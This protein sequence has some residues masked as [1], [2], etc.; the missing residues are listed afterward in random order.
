MESIP[1]T[2][3]ALLVSVTFGGEP[4]RGRWSGPGRHLPYSSVRGAQKGSSGLG[5][6]PVNGS[7]TL[8]WLGLAV[9]GFLL[10]DPKVWQETDNSD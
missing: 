5:K 3:G 8:L 7:W 10:G 6:V 4:N 2:S 9:I 1:V